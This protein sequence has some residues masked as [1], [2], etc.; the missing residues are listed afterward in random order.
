MAVD[1]ERRD[2][3]LMKLDLAGQDDDKSRYSEENDATQSN[4]LEEDL[5][6]VQLGVS[7]LEE[8][9]VRTYDGVM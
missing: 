2:T 8:R 9:L 3:M 4:A 1:D 6:A 5:D 7:A